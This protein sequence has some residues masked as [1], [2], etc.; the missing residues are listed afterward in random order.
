MKIAVRFEINSNRLFPFPISVVNLTE[1]EFRELF[2][3]NL[4]N[5][6]IEGVIKSQP[7]EAHFAQSFKQGNVAVDIYKLDE[8]PSIK[9]FT[10]VNFSEMKYTFRG[11]VGKDL[12][13]ET[14]Q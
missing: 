13:D 2:K 7:N 10:E 9:N 3:D 1:S 4:S 6:E 11:K 12:T 14:E 5:E 8:N